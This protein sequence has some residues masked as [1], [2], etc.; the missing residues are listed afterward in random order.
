MVTTT[1]IWTAIEDSLN[2]QMS[3]PH[4]KASLAGLPPDAT[5]G[6]IDRW[7]VEQ[8]NAGVAAAA[9]LLALRHLKTLR[10]VAR[11][12]HVDP[13]DWSEHTAVQVQLTMTAFY[14]T[15][16]DL[17]AA[18]DIA[19][20]I[21]W[22]TLNLIRR[23]RGH[24]GPVRDSSLMEIP[25]D[26][27]C[28]AALPDDL[29]DHDGPRRRT[30]TRT[31]AH[32]LCDPENHDEDITVEDLADWARRRTDKERQALE[33]LA[34]K[35]MSDD[36]PLSARQLALNLGLSEDGVES[37][38]RRARARLRTA[39]TDQRTGLFADTSVAA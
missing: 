30:H 22:K 32:Q 21:Y 10:A 12:A 11:R 17:D 8:L 16:A 33:L 23:H 28:A 15:L 9:T 4:A 3:S 1:T 34:A 37:Q 36:A 31:M 29:A 24:R 27:T 19:T 39:L 2:R 14:E 35:F 20:A 25:V 6:V 26:L 18:E 7:L 13:W 38:V 5:P